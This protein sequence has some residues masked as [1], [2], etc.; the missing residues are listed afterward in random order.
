MVRQTTD[1]REGMRYV[2]ALHLS[3]RKEAETRCVQGMKITAHMDG[4]ANMTLAYYDG[5]FIKAFVTACPP[6]LLGTVKM[7]DRWEPVMSGAEKV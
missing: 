2:E 7:L 3:P 6:G 4:P 1:G 5:C